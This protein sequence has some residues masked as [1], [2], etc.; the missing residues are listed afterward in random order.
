MMLGAIALILLTILGCYIW[1][2]ESDDKNRG[3]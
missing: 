3:A 2:S 1:Y